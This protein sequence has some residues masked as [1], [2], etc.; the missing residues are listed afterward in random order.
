MKKLLAALALTASTA[1]QAQVMT[2]NDWLSRYHAPESLNRMQALGYVGGVVDSSTRNCAPSTVTV[3]QIS[4]MTSRLI[5]ETPGS[6][7]LPASA[8]INAVLEAAWP[9]KQPARRENL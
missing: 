9:C 5:T 8:F 1:A 6:R 7:H 3:G 4:D 2:G